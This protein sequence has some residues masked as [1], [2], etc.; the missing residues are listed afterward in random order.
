[1]ILL[2][3]ESSLMTVSLA[4][5]LVFT[6]IAAPAALYLAALRFCGFR[7]HDWRIFSVCFGSAPA[8]ISRL[9][10]WFLYAF[11]GGADWTYI[12]A[13][14]GLMSLL[15]IYGHNRAAV[16]IRLP[17]EVAAWANR[18][19]EAIIIAIAVAIATTALVRIPTVSSFLVRSYQ[20]STTGWHFSAEGWAGVMPVFA[21]VT[22]LGLVIS[23][24]W[25]R[26]ASGVRT[27]ATR[28][29]SSV[30][31]GVL[32]GFILSAVFIL[33]I[34]QLGRP[35]YESDALNYFKIATIL[36]ENKSLGL[37]PLVSPQPDGMY[38][39]SAHPLG[40]LGT[41]LWSFM[42][43]GGAVP[44]VARL[45]VLMALV[46]TLVG[47][48]V[49]LPP[50]RPIA[51]LA[52]MLILITTPG[53]AAQVL[54]AGIDAHRLA[55]FLLTVIALALAGEHQEM[56][57]W[58]LAGVV[59][60]LSLNSHSL[61][62]L[63]VPIAI[64]ATIGFNSNIPVRQRLGAMLIVSSIAFLVGGERYILNLIQFGTPLYNDAVLFELMPELDYHGWRFG[65]A[66]R[67]DFWGRL[68]SGGLMG[69]TY[70]SFFGL[71]WW[72]GLLAIVV[73]TNELF[74][75]PILKAMGVTVLLS[76]AVL[77]I[78]FAFTSAGELLIANYRYVMSLQP[79]VAAL[80]G[81]LIGNLYDL[82]ASDS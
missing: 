66:P 42:L 45:S 16:F 41:L 68:S 11:P 50:W 6:Y 54:A 74:G 60:G 53:Y 21:T 76:F 24:C 40:Y 10:T 18:S 80:G 12:A 14:V 28:P 52:A 67:Q 23:A 15:A 9:V 55:L 56:R 2:L 79:M 3:G 19:T 8:L 47:L 38:D 17:R 81:F 7:G 63:L 77:V 26:L 5:G 58:A 72:L 37:Y 75:T 13:V 82:R 61:M 48:W 39:P 4:L 43:A 35:V 33:A 78:F 27:R 46:A 36:Y 51:A 32:G 44:G 64:T 70:W 20:S 22:L 30:V 49:T 73:R 34:L 25:M 69:F 29:I 71:S 59:A 62:A 65:L 1:M 57:S 31:P